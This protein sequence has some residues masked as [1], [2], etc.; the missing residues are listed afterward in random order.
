MREVDFKQINEEDE[1]IDISAYIIRMWEKRRV[2]LIIACV[3][4]VL[5]IISALSKP[6]VYSAQSVFVPQVSTS[7][8]SSGRLRG[9]ASMMGLN[10]GSMEQTSI[11]SPMVYPNI[12]NNVDLQKELIYSKYDFDGVD[13]D[14]VTFYDYYFDPKYKKSNIISVVKKYTIGL[15]SLIIGLFKKESKDFISSGDSSSYI[16]L[17]NKEARCIKMLKS[18][19]SLSIDSKNGYL[20]LTAKMPS[21]VSSAQLAMYTQNLLQKYITEFRVKKAKEQLNYINGRYKEAKKDYEEKQEAYAKFQDA[22]R[23][24]STAVAQAR[25]QRLEDEY[26]LANTLYT[27]LATQKIQ[28]EMQVKED[29]PVLTI[30]EPVL[31][32]NG[33]SGPRKRIIIAGYLF[34]GLIFG[35]CFVFILDYIKKRFDVSKVKFLNKWN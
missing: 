21:A 22:N 1:E 29:T 28:A 11:L 30:I 17:T 23:G 35:G 4:L 8:K 34:F 26:N 10:L 25:G 14:S 19:I 31:V 3:C 6:G 13:A 7:S 32:P 33:K 20:T 16:V 5:G 15:P 27:Q 2:I 24:L 9:L 18:K 12:L